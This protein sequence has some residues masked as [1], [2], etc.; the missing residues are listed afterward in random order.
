MQ[1]DDF[2][3]QDKANLAS[4]IAQLGNADDMADLVRLIRADIDRVRRGRKARAEGGRSPLSNGGNMS[5]SGWHVEAVLQLGP[6]G[7]EKVL[8]DLLSQPEYAVDAAQAMSRDFHPTPERAFDRTFRYE[9]IWAAREGCLPAARDDARRKRYAAALNAEIARLLKLPEEVRPMRRLNEL[10]KALAAIDGRASGSVVLD[11]VALPAQWEYTR[12]DAVELLLTSGAVVPSAPAFG[13]V[14]SILER[15]AKYGMQESEKYLF[16]R[17]IALCAFV[18][19]PAKGV[20]KMREA[21]TARRVGFYELREIVTALGESRS[22]AA[23]DYLI[24]LASNL[25]TFEQCEDNFFNAFAALDT[26]RAREVL[27]GFIDP[28]AKG[29]TL[30]RRPQREDV[31]VARITDLARRAPAI[32]KRLIALCERDLPDLSRHILSK[33]MN[34]LGTSEALAASL[35]LID[36]SKGGG[37]I[38]WRVRELLEGAFV[39][40]RPYGDSPGVFTQHARASNE[41]RTSLFKMATEDAKRRK[42]A[43]ALLGQIE[44]WRLERGRPTGEPR[45]P[46]FQSG[47][48][49]PPTKPV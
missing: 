42:S 19:E 45:H 33:V 44:E 6:A 30:P 17:A 16:R 47:A 37:A 8:I 15:T 25:Q 9:L 49:W 23:V 22:D 4:A 36:D 11:V 10:A 2:D 34:W 32:A 39:E 46:D 40:R 3:G 18:D 1:Q 26:P 12:T 43:F 48:P 20:V 28:E 5:Y 27:V 35:N 13:I 7:A 14:D 21:V 31:L 29:I 41:L 24:E 38:P